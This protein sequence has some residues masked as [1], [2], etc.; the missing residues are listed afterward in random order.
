NDLACGEYRA[1][2][3]KEACSKKSSLDEL[4]CLG[5]EINFIE[6][7]KGSSNFFSSKDSKNKRAFEEKYKRE[8]EYKI[9][10]LQE[11]FMEK[12]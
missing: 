11:L 6:E 4:L 3:N 10:G 8:L 1:H 12:H 5:Q 2:P 9:K 7:N